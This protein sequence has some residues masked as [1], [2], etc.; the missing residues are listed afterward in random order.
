MNKKGYSKLFLFALLALSVIV[1]A[2]FI[3]DDNADLKPAVKKNRSTHPKDHHK[4]H[5]CGNG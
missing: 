1:A 2:V 5:Y 4:S 3:M